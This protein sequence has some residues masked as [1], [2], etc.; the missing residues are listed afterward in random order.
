MEK[1]R[2]LITNYLSSKINKD[3]KV[4]L[5][6]SGGFESFA[7]LITLL[8]IGCKPHLYTF[9]LKDANSRDMLKAEKDAV[10]FN[11]PLTKVII[12]IDKEKLIADVK[13]IIRDWKTSRKTVIQ[14]LHPLYYTI[15]QIK[16]IKIVSG[17]EKGNIWGDTKNG[18]ISASKGD[19]E[20]NE[21]RL[22]EV[23][24]DKSGSVYY[25]DK[26][27]EKLNHVSVRPFGDDAIWGW[28]MDKTYDFLNKPKPKQVILDEFSKEIKKTIQP[29][30]ANYQIESGFK[31]YHDIL[32]D[33]ETLNPNHKYKS[34]V[35]IYNQL[36]KSINN[37]QI[38]LPLEFK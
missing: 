2:T 34:V 7:C 18:A 32:L 22:K 3:E 29:K 23:E 25:F 13:A 19:E 12:D 17:L 33:D 21:Y 16:E 9:S 36:L 15:P 20:F 6:Y 38:Q 31:K 26:Y 14:C 4:A 24:R 1:L 30:T 27:I 5:L 10:I 8:E 11:V 28:F 37:A 35:G